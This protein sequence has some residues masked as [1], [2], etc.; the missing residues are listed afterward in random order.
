MRLTHRP[1]RKTLYEGN[2]P[3]TGAI[4]QSIRPTVVVM[5]T[6]HP[7]KGEWQNFYVFPPFLTKFSLVNEPLILMR[8]LT[9]FV[10]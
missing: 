7:K 2:N 4:G 9:Y 5:F 10:R 6:A 1:P 8:I 3:Q